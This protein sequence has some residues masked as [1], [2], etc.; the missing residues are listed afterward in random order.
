[1]LAP[2]LIYF[3]LLSKAACHLQNIQHY[4]LSDYTIPVLQK[5]NLLRMIKKKITEELIQ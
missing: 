3:Y 4:A 1:M 5:R 2:I